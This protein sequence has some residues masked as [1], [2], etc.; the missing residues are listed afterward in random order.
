MIIVRL[1]FYLSVSI[2]I[3]TMYLLKSKQKLKRISLLILAPYVILCITAGG[4][5]A[6]N[7]AVFHG[8]SVEK[9]HS[10]NA[11]VNA[12][13][14]GNSTLFFC[15]N[16]HNEDTCAICKWLKHTPKRVKLPM[17]VSSIIL[18]TSGLCVNKHQAYYFLNNCEY[19]SRAPPLFIS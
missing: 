13:T 3:N 1:V 2:I 12:D 10:E 9:I 18:G 19:H 8:H 6:F 16:D 11:V 7:E 17:D 5:H 4:F 15:Y 14:S